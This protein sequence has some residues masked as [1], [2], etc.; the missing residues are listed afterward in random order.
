M[1]WRCSNMHYQSATCIF[2][3]FCEGNS[4]DCARKVA[5][6]LQMDENVVFIPLELSKH[7]IIRLQSQRSPQL[8]SCPRCG[9]AVAYV[10]PAAVSAPNR[11]QGG[12]PRL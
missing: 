1:G 11:H 12:F 9:V 6:G 2:G 10:L 3:F 8:T 4:L 7:T 5:Q